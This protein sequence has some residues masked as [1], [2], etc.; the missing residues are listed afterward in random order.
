MTNKMFVAEN[1]S[2]I[3]VLDIRKLQEDSSDE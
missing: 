1:Q 3:I 2:A